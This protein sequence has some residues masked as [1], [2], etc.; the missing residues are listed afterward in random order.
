MSVVVVATIVPVAGQH[1]AVKEALLEAIPKVHAEDGC[2]LYA[3][4]ERA[5]RLVMVEQWSSE[6]AL[7]E[8]SRGAALAE[9]GG[10]L[11]G[12]TTGAPDVVVLAAVP[13]GDTA[14]G[15]LLP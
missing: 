7:A 3:L 14:K 6:Q 13:A 12:R 10:R 4:H 15:R 11:A 2:E 8:H 1:E 9:L 5:D